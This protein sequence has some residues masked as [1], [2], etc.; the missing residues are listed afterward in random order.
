M[1]GNR[2]AQNVSPWYMDHNKRERV[3]EESKSAEF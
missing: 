2:L 3:G 1:R